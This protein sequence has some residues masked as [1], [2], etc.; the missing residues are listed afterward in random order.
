[1]KLFFGEESYLIN[2]EISRVSRTLDIL[3]TVFTE[4]DSLESIILDLT[5]VSMFFDKKLVVIKNH[6]CLTNANEAKTL[7]EEIKDLDESIQI[8]FALEE[9]KLPKNALIE[10]IQSKGEAKEFKKLNE[11]NVVSTIKEIVT[12]KGGS[13]TNGAAIRLANKVPA[14][15]R[16]I[17]NEVEK[18]LMQTS[19]ITDEV[20]EVSIGEYV[21]EDA[22]A[23]ANALSANDAHA[24][25]R[26][27]KERKDAEQEVGMIIGQISSVL[28]LSLQVDS[29]R[30]QGLTN[31]DISDKTKIHIFRI[32]K[33]SDLI[34][35]AS[36]EKIKSLI[37]K[38]AQLDADIKTGKVDE[39]LGLDNFILSVIK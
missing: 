29:L 20:I 15:L 26:A 10:L 35:K 5:T 28:S 30:K 31:Q 9:A 1:M 22:F 25:L 2:Q 27:Y 3:P 24:I 36:I 14:D 8:I 13:I 6:S 7:A 37:V 17:V 19:S 23:L 33:A 18:L 32:K 38:L 16:I 12:S 4:E 39:Q 21:K 11:N 34:S